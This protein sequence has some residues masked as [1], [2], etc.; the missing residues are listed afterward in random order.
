MKST[1]CKKYL[2]YNEITSDVVRLHLI[3][4]GVNKKDIVVQSLN[5][6]LGVFS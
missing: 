6:S 1:S 2:V 3:I 5:H 4:T